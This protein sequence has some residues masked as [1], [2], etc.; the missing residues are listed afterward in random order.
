MA[1]EFH[2]HFHVVLEGFAVELALLA[3]SKHDHEKF[4]QQAQRNLLA[5]HPNDE[6]RTRRYFLR[7]EKVLSEF[8]FG[9]LANH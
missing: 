2:H 4:A 3:A 6:G 7:V 8:T 9:C 1:L 5:E